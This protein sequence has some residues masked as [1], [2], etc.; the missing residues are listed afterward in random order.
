M[1]VFLLCASLRVQA[2]RT[3]LGVEIGGYNYIGDVTRQYDFTNHTTG[4]Q[5]FMRK[6]LNDAFSTRLSVGFG[7]LQGADDQAFDVFA[8]NRRAAFLGDFTNVDFL[9]E[10]HFLDFRNEKLQQY[11]TPYLFFGIGAYRLKGTDGFGNEYNTGVN[12]RFPVGAGIKYRLDRRW[13]IGASFAAIK[14]SSDKLDNVSIETSNIKNYRGGN[15]NDDD[16]IFFSSISLSYTFYRIVCPKP[17][18]KYR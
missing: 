11:W 13:I 2:Q 3:E 10:Y 5:I 4:A 16:W 7:K 14:S 1:L 18:Y 6:N 12:V 17:W 8:A 9:F 15:P